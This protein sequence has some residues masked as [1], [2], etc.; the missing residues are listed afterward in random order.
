MET[1]RGLSVT[2]SSLPVIESINHF[3]QQI[4]GSGATPE[5]ILAAVNDNPDN[6]L[7]QTYAAIFYLYGQR[8]P[9]TAL[10]KEHLLQA[11]QLIRTANLREKLIYYAAQAW[12]NL[13]YQNA[14]TLLT[15]VTELYPRDTLA[16][17]FAEW[18]FYCV[19]QKCTA[20]DYLALCQRMA[21]ENQDES[22]FIAMHAFAYELSGY[23]PE[24]QYEAEKA[25]ALE[26]VTP[27]AHHALAHAYLKAN[28]M[29]AGIA[30]M[31]AFRGT[32]EQ[33]TPLLRGHNS[34][35]LALFYLALRQEDKV[36]ELYPYIFGFS[37]QV[38]TEQMDALS[39]LWR[40]DLAG[41]PQTKQFHAVAKYFSE[42]PWEHYTGF[43][44]LH[45]IYGLARLGRANEVQKSI[46]A[47][48]IYAQS[49]EK[50]YAQT[51]WSAV[52][53][54]FS[55]AINAFVQHDFSAA[56]DWMTPCIARYAEM[57][58][59]DAQAELFAQTYLICLIKLKKTTAANQFFNQHLAYYQG[60]PLAEFWFAS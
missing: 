35:H 37:P 48:E 57:G 15:S 40:L 33:I 16:A 13:D 50:G 18:L 9:A 7:V 10:A 1:N 49:L 31:E 12:M 53:V 23:L 47:I 20:A 2:T 32:W 28:N 46:S 8:D 19:G 4:L 3:H 36:M 14:L 27:W 29:H 17:K 34:W 52:I 6:L 58:G 55:K 54:P 42:G 51:L 25:I 41:L 44:S 11:E 56:Y 24:A 59:S 38:V 60:T 26:L 21:K 39:M 22:H 5:L 45:Y 43:N 30:T